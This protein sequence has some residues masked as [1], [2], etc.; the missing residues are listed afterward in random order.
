MF[1]TEG[2]LSREAA[3]DLTGKYGYLV[4]FG[5]SGNVNKIVLAAATGDS[6]LGVL[7]NEPKLGETAAIALLNGDGSREGKAGGSITAGQYL[8]TDSAGKLVAATQTT[9]GAQPIVHV[10]GRALQDAASGDL[11]EFELKDFLY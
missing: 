8:T 7:T 2:I 11:F 9:A 1:V 5:T 10:V 4:K 3:A 6:I